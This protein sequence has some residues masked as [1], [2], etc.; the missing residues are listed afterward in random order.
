MRALAAANRGCELKLLAGMNHVLKRV[1]PD[2]AL[3][4]ASY[5][6]PSLPLAPDLVPTLNDFLARATATSQRPPP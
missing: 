6:D 4:I 1:A 2:R 5:G 3:Q